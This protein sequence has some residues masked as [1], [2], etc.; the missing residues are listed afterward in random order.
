[1]DKLQ[2][3]CSTHRNRKTA[4]LNIYQNHFHI[5][6]HTNCWSMWVRACVFNLL[7]R[8]SSDCRVFRTWYECLRAILWLNWIEHINWAQHQQ[9]QQQKHTTAI[10][11]AASKARKSV[12][13]RIPEIDLRWLVTSSNTHSVPYSKLNS[14]D[15]LKARHKHTLCKRI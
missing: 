15:I 12:S 9:K 1:M 14:T 11:A 3:N 5:W 4:K 13:S 10:V 8:N 7:N 6:F 2:I